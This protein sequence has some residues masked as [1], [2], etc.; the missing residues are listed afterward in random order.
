MGPFLKAAPGRSQRGVGAL[1]IAIVFIAATAVGSIMAVTLL[2]LSQ[3]ATN[4]GGAAAERGLNEA[5]GALTLRGGVLTARGSVD[6]DGDNAINLAGDDDQAVV[7]LSFVL[8]ASDGGIPVDLTPPYTTDSTG[9]DPDS[10]GLAYSTLIGFSSG[11]FQVTD[12]AWTISF[13]GSDDG[14]YMLEQGE[15]AEITL[16]LHRYDGA[17]AHYDLGAGSGDPYVDTSAGLLLANEPFSIEVRV[18]GGGTLEIQ[19]VTPLELG[20]S[21]M[22]E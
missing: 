1:D 4:D 12:G 18:K 11:D 16:W 6:V 2:N 13:P 9:F 21:D 5:A 20:A 7:K 22:L 17:N 15:R 3:R 19:R 14:D 10:S 8:A